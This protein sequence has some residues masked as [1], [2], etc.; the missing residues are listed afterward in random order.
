MVYGRDI[1]G[2]FVCK[3]SLLL[4]QRVWLSVGFEEP[5][6]KIEPLTFRSNPR[7]FFYFVNAQSVAVS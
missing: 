5:Q 1:F 6:V 3:P 2:E 7:F 4:G